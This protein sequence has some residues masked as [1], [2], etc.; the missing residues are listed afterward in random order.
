A[1][2]YQ[3]KPGESVI[4]PRML[5]VTPGY[6]EAL[7]IKLVRGR[8]FDEQDH[9]NASTIIVDER[10]ARKFWPNTNPIGRRMYQPDDANDLLKV[11]RNTRWRTVVGV[12]RDVRYQ[13]LDGSGN[14][15]GTY[16]F[17]YAQQPIATVGLVIRS[18]VPPET[19]IREVR[20]EIA[21]IDPQ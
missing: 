8:L 11:T 7:G 14:S 16:Y 3:L 18:T 20:A 13:D 15:A 5:I 21:K 6:F 1:E 4:S 17:P 10:L 9:E 12:L 2:G 19:L